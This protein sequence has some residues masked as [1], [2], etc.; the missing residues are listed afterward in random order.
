[1]QKVVAVLLVAAASGS[2]GTSVAKFQPGSGSVFEIKGSQK[3]A[4]L[5]FDLAP[6]PARNTIVSARLEVVL[7]GVGSEP[8]IDPKRFAVTTGDTR[9][10]N[11]V[12]K[13]AGEY[14]VDVTRQARMG[15]TFAITIAGLEAN[16]SATVSRA[17]VEV[18]HSDTAPRADAGGE[19]FQ[20]PGQHGAMRVDGSKSALPDG[21]TAGLSYEWR[22]EKPAWGSSYRAGERLGTAAVLSFAPKTPGYYVLKLRVTN[23]ATGE[24]T[25]DSVGV[26]TALRPHPR[27]QVDEDVIAQIRKLRDARDPL[28]ERFYKRLQSRPSASAPGLQANL[29]TSYL[30]A[31]M[32][33][34]E[35]EMFEEAWKLAAAKLYKNGKDR[36]G[37][38]VKLI[39]LYGGDQHKA[40]FQ[41]GQFTGQMAVLYDWGYHFLTPEQRQD[42][43]NWLNEAV[44][45]NYLQSHAAQAMMRNDG[46]AVTYGLAAAAYATLDENPEGRK[47][48]HWF[49][50]LWDIAV[51]GLDVIGKGGA[52]GEGNA[53]GASPTAYNFIR[54]ANTAYYAS[55][56]DLFL[57]HVY[58]RQR[59]L[60]DAFGAYP[61]S[62][63][64]PG[65]VAR[66]PDRPII[67][68]A[69]IA[70]DAEQ[71]RQVFLNLLINAIQ[72]TEEGGSLALGIRAVAGGWEVSIADDGCGIPEETLEKIFDPFFTTKD[73]GSGIGLAIVHTILMAHH[74]RIEV[75]SRVGEGTTFRVTFP[76][77]R[78]FEGA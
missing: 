15:R 72:A 21:S 44:T 50:G 1:M 13:A 39:E 76:G 29:W 47:L 37:G 70:G 61:G 2:A 74:A 24:S 62:I 20:A 9:I 55:G 67:E 45:Y 4:L 16:P 71:L 26:M 60:F 30:L 51:A 48:F 38:V 22:I 7:D 19:V 53:Y 57:S 63:G 32:V 8:P 69:S 40:A 49:R 43:I 31:S 59:L 28:W 46:A 6:L 23:P 3:K 41:G 33:T 36:S 73:K 52:S 35:R 10:A 78:E 54:A 17:T 12:V 11:L 56:E 18:R 64:G 5:R 77:V 66:F 14:S 27:L 42:I 25:E 34:G 75:E 68:Q 65:A 58:F